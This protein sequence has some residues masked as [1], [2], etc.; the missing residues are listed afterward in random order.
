VKHA[1]PELNR[2]LE[3]TYRRHRKGSRAAVEAG[4]LTERRA[5]TNASIAAWT[6]V[7]KRFRKERK[8]ADVWV[9]KKQDKRKFALQEQP[10]YY[11]DPLFGGISR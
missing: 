8:M 9:P 4:T 3:E 5:K 7:K 10:R 6:N 1:P 11:V 2:I